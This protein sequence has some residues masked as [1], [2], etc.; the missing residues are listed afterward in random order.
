[1]SPPACIANVDRSSAR[2]IHHTQLKDSTLDSLYHSHAPHYRDT[3][4]ASPLD[5]LQRV[6]LSRRARR[7]PSL[8]GQPR[9]SEHE[10]DAPCRDRISCNIT[11]VHAPNGVRS[12]SAQA[13]LLEP[14]LVIRPAAAPL[15]RPA[16]AGLAAASICQEV[17]GGEERR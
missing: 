11:A 15:A 6:E 1:M 16:L 13:A 9:P 5:F 2:H 4:L 17:L 8:A 7:A 12:G 14:G 3:P 10:S